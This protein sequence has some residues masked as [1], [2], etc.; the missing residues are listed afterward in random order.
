MRESLCEYAGGTAAF[1]NLVAAHHKR[2]LDD[3][4]LNHPFTSPGL[5]SEHVDRLAAYLAEVMGGQTEVEVGSTLRNYIEWTV[6]GILIYSSIGAEVLSTAV[7]P[8]WGWDGL[9]SGTAN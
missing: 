5:N 8:R 3:S 1:R 7:L 2:C 4:E 9:E 6:A